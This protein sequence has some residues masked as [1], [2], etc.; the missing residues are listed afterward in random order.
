[1]DSSR[2]GTYLDTI[3]D[4]TCV[5]SEM[6]YAIKVH[7]SIL[8]PKY[9]LIKP[10]NFPSSIRHPSE[11]KSVKLKWV[12]VMTND[13][14]MIQDGTEIILK[15]GPKEMRHTLCFS[16]RI[17]K[18][19]HDNFHLYKPINNNLIMINAR[20]HVKKET[21]I[22]AIKAVKHIE[23]FLEWCHLPSSD[24][25]ISR[26]GSGSGGRS[27][28]SSI[29][30]NCDF[31]KFAPR[32]KLYICGVVWEPAAIMTVRELIQHKHWRNYIGVLQPNRQ[33]IGVYDVTN[34][35]GVTS[36]SV[37]KHVEYRNWLRQILYKAFICITPD[38]ETPPRTPKRRYSIDQ[39]ELG[40]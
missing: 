19:Q 15:P 38:L 1:M 32:V 10:N 11:A 22:K 33:R 4:N 2:W 31:D 40:L 14:D 8:Y 13:L 17:I 18:L 34:T 27:C 6:T 26:T 28:I 20:H 39:D 29:I 23:A 37:I 7:I 3:D 30:E 25:H 12:Y 21:I 16:K 24:L 9:T 35:F 36:T 5:K